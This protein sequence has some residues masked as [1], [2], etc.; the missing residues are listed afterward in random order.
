MQRGPA[1]DLLKILIY[2]VLPLAALL[3]ALAVYL[4]SC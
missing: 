1:R 4:K 3:V 2:I